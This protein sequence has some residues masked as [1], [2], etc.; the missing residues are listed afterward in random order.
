MAGIANIRE[1]SSEEIKAD[2]LGHKKETMN[3][4]FRKASGDVA[5]NR[6]RQLRKDVARMK[7]VL[8]ERNMMEFKKNA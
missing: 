1:K 6:M 7:T 3:L 5:I 4:R 8:N 2:I